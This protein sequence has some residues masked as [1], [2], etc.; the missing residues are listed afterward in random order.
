[1]FSSMVT[2]FCADGNPFVGVNGDCNSNFLD[3]SVAVIIHSTF[4]PD[5]ESAANALKKMDGRA[6]SEVTKVS[7]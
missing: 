3:W 1:M 5:V 4:E 2:M 7:Y 6:M